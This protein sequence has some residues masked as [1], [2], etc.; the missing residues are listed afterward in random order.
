MRKCLQRRFRDVVLDALGVG[1]RR[2]GRN[3]QRTQHVDHKPMANA[4][5][6]RKPFPFF[7]EEHTPIRPRCCEPRTLEALNRLDR[8]GV[9]MLR[10]RATSVGRA[11][12]EPFANR[13]A[14][15]ST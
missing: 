11:S 12:P 2:F 8:G 9:R 5:A 7:G 6:L 14:I 4:H 10:R 3:A 13:S 15:S 1:L